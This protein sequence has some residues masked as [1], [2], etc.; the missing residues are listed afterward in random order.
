MTLPQIFAALEAM[1]LPENRAL[2]ARHGIPPPT[3]G[4]AFRHLRALAKQIGTSPTMAETLWATRNHDARILA[5]LVAGERGATA[6]RLRA[7]AGTLD[8]YVIADLLARWAATAKAAPA[9]SEEWIAA[10]GEWTARAGWML[11]ALLA[12]DRPELPDEAF[13]PSIGTIEREIHRAKNRVRDAMNMALIAIGIGRASLTEQAIAAARRI[14]PVIVDFGESGGSLAPTEETILRGLEQRL[15]QESGRAGGKK[16]ASR[17]RAA[18]KKSGG[19][20]KGGAKKKS[21]R[22]GRP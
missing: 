1:G 20:K 12:I 8:N 19:E 18:V 6:A 4:A 14:G 10:R 3:Y 7:W 9:L 5:T 16:A 15:R 11:H 21:S 13:A 2:Y 22:R 17:K